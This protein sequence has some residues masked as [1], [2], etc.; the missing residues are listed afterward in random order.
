MSL[1]N[2]GR[3][4]G[5][6]LDWQVLTGMWELGARLISF[7][8][9]M[10][11]QPS[12]PITPTPHLPYATNLTLFTFGFTQYTVLF[13]PG[14]ICA[15]IGQGGRTFVWSF[16]F[17]MLKLGLKPAPPA[18][19]QLY[20]YFIVYT[21]FIFYNSQIKDGS[22]TLCFWVGC[23][24]VAEA[25]PTSHPTLLPSQPYLYKHP[26]HTTTNRPPFKIIIVNIHVQNMSGGQPIDGNSKVQSWIFFAV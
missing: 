24:I 8:M 22:K 12:P 3:Q 1:L 15:R 10:R 4:A 11:H 21:Y 7:Q 14:T 13:S 23:K 18:P 25:W 19:L 17:D 6:E 20:L 9:V 16:L 26:S 2:E 5:S